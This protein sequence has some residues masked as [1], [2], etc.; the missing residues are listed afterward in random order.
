VISRDLLANMSGDEKHSETMSD[1]S[2]DSEVEM[3]EEDEVEELEIPPE[4]QAEVKK[5]QGNS[6]YVQKNYSI[7][8]KLYTEAIE[9]CPSC[10][11][12]Y[13]NRAA[14]YMMLRQ[15][16]K[17][18]KDARHSTQIDPTFTKGH[19]RE[20]KCHLAMG[21][22]AT[23]TC[24]YQKVL[25][26]D[27]T[28]TA[29]MNELNQ[30]KTAQQ[31]ADS[32]EQSYGKNDFRRVIF[33]MDRCIELSPECSKFRVLKAEC[34]ALLKR[35][36]EAQE[37]ANDML[38]WD[39]M[40]ADA[41][42]V[43]GLCLYYQDSID[44]AFQH[45]TQ[46]LRLAPDHIKARGVYRKAKLL[47]A[48]KDEG[49][50]AFRVGKLTDAHGLYTEALAIDP[51]NVFTNSKL[52]NN[53]ATVL[54]RQNKLDEAIKD[55]NEAIRL[56]STYVKAYMRRAK[57]YADSELHDEAVR[58]YQK[59]FDMDKTRENKKLLGEAKL[60]L[61]KSKRK[62]YYKI[63]AITK[64]AT[65]EEIKKAYKKRAMVHHPDRH[66]NVSDEEKKEQEKKFKEVGEAYAVLSDQKKKQRYDSGADIEDM[67]GGGGYAD[68]D[69]NLIF[70]TFFN[71]GG[72]GFSHGGGGHGHQ[73]SHGMHG[74]GFPGGFS[75][76]FG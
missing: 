16:D 55:C 60:E 49:N 18:L 76:Q 11:A 53:R 1:S 47:A 50:N 69:P 29:A 59:I 41:I 34:L 61:K 39:S 62:D 71:G 7:A 15:Y 65:P 23:A 63:L 25:D 57:C 38:R 45:F 27:S 54:A 8:L 36:Q 5:N 66:A 33:C 22:L 10:A 56:D 31:H 21:E 9:L 73:H 13:S 17:A 24:C 44:K 48:K 30:V 20:A 28:N 67:E 51:L 14:T 70:Q 74:G 58:D 26:L 2:S 43:R 40:N 3:V 35:Y 32:A 52:Y 46:V 42:Y 68:I 6:Y 72:G 37:I 19:L 64:Q 75:F 4:E 12:Y